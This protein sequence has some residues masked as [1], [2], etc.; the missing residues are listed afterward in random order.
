MKDIPL[1]KGGEKEKRRE[2]V[3]Y[4]EAVQKERG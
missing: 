1:K 4:G 2:V 3:L